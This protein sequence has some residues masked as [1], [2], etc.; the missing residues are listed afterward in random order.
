[1]EEGGTA[2]LNLIVGL[3]N[4]G[5]AYAGT[6]HNIGFRCVSWFARLQSISLDHQQCRARVG[7]GWVA[8]REVVVAKPRTYMNASGESVRLLM[9]KHG[10]SLE[11]LIVVHDDMDLPLGKIRL[12]PG[13]SS[14]GH[15]GIDSII[16]SLGSQDF[17]RIKVGVG[18]PTGERDE[19]VDHVLSG[20][21]RDEGET[22]KEA[23]S[24]VVEAL[25]YLLAEG[26][27]AAMNRFN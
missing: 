26:I 12:R 25:S 11:D 20:F 14:G 13:G 23:I 6:R 22:I 18:H 8:G 21:A 27:D 24:K 10:V 15:K 7:V 17:A 1:M 16:A 5:S 3:G 4:P 2:R 9:K 19:V